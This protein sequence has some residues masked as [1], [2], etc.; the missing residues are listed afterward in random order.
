V[1]G[2]GEPEPSVVA[3]TV[4]GSGLTMCALLGLLSEEADVP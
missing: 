3:L 4:L 1:E 2:V